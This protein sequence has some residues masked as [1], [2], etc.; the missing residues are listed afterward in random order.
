MKKKVKNPKSPWR[1]GHVQSANAW[2]IRKE[3]AEKRRAIL[4]T[5]PGTPGTAG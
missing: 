1:I 3:F 4:R 2:R 5:P